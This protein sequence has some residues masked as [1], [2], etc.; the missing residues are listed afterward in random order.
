MGI[1]IGG[2]KGSRQN[3]LLSC[4][5]VYPLVKTTH[6]SHSYELNATFLWFLLPFFSVESSFCEPMNL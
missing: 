4:T 1:T 6:R 5:V 2:D 3:L